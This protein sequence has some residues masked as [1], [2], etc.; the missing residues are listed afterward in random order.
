M[1]NLSL[2]FFNLATDN[3]GATILYSCSSSARILVLQFAAN[4]RF[5]SHLLT[6]H[7]NISTFTILEGEG[8]MKTSFPWGM[9]LSKVTA[10]PRKR[11]LRPL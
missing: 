7:H 8:H 6:Q 5:E 9:A 4:L 1:K 10:T 11:Q 2:V 3:C